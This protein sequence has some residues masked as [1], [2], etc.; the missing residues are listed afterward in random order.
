[1]FAHACGNAEFALI[2]DADHLAQFERR[3]ACA[4]LYGPFCAARHCRS[5][6]RAARGSAHAPARPG[7]TLR[8]P[9]S[10][11][12]RARSAGTSAVRRL[13][14][15]T[16]GTRLFR[17]EAARRARPNPARNA[18]GGCAATAWRTWTSCP[19]A[20][21]PAASP[22]SSRTPIRRP[23]PD[24]PTSSPPGSEREVA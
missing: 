24:W 21:P 6:P 16:D 8:G 18:A 19:C 9:P 3:E 12:P 1:M 23:A 17:R 11:S 4:R 15:G 7:A 14:G 13:C 22:S 5:A 2:H 20:R 10:A